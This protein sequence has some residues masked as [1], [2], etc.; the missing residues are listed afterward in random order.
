MRSPEAEEALRP[1]DVR[2]GADGRCTQSIRPALC[3]ARPRSSLRIF[4]ARCIPNNRCISFVLLL[5]SVP[6]LCPDCPRLAGFLPVCPSSGSDRNFP[7]AD[8]SGLNF[9]VASSGL[10]PP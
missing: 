2:W 4:L 8:L 1:Q 9:L 10:S 6:G 3:L 7:Q 5:L